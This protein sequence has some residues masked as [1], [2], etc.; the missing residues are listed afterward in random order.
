MHCIPPTFIRHRTQEVTVDPQVPPSNI[1]LRT[2]GVHNMPVQVFQLKQPNARVISSFTYSNNDPYLPIYGTYPMRA[3]CQSRY[4]LYK[5]TGATTTTTTEYHRTTTSSPS[6]ERLIHTVPRG[7]WDWDRG[8][9]LARLFT[10]FWRVVLAMDF[11]DVP[12]PLW[13]RA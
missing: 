7:V 8:R 12:D 3:C 5:T 9:R 4:V 2:C 10:K 1:R 13:C 11:A 6:T